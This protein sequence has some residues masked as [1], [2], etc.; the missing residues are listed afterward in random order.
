MDQFKPS[1][2]DTQSYKSVREFADAAVAGVQYLSKFLAKK[3]DIKAVEDVSSLV[4]TH[5]GNKLG[6]SNDFKM[7]SE[8]F[9]NAMKMVDAMST[10]SGF[11]VFEM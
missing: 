8:E 7:V 9:K 3:S 4:L 1:F 2:G 11:D 5:V 6:T 10:E